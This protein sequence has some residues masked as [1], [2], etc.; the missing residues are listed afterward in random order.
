[1]RKAKEGEFRSRVY[2]DRPAY[3]DLEKIRPYEP[4]VVKASWNIFGD[5]YRFRQK[6]NEYKAQRRAEEKALKTKDEGEPL[7]GQVSLDI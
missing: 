4:N 3:A 5:S 1:M 7:K 6:Y 2:E